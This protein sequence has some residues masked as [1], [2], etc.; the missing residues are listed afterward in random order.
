MY[1]TCSDS[2]TRGRVAYGYSYSSCVRHTHPHSYDDA[3]QY[4]CTDGVGHTHTKT[5]FNDGTNCHANA[6]ANSNPCTN[7]DAYT[8]PNA[9]SY[10]HAEPNTGRSPR[11]RL[12]PG[13]RDRGRSGGHYHPG[14]AV[15]RRQPSHTVSPD[16]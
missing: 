10:A 4:L 7:G 6:D 13:Q 11:H 1:S 3:N 14:V 12:L 5:D 9:R 8:Y 2:Y 16:E 15:Q